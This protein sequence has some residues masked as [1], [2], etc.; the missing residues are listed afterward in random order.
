MGTHT[1]EHRVENSPMEEHTG[2][3]S[4]SHLVEN[5][6]GAKVEGGRGQ[7]EEGRGGG[8]GRREGEEG[9]GGGKGRR[10]GEEGRGGGKG[11]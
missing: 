4:T 5:G 2:S 11:W 7:G 9:R 10:E 3:G 6:G 1:G 8:K